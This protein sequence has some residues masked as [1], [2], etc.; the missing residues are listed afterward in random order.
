MT[1]LVT[2]SARARQSFVIRFKL[3]LFLSQARIYVSAGPENAAAE[4]TCVYV[5]SREHSPLCATL[6]KENRS[7]EMR[8]RMH[9]KAHHD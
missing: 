7:A 9:V 8:R 2:R 4:G 3:R 6:C 5:H 1:E